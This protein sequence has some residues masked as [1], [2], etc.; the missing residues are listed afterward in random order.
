M[1]AS[2]S[3]AAAITKKVGVI[4]TGISKAFEKINHSL[5]L[6]KLRACSFSDQALRLSIQQI[7]E[8]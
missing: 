7:S 6:A 4:F 1:K 8:K 2:L 3:W 5:L